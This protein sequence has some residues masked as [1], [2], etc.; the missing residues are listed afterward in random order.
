MTPTRGGPLPFHIRFLSF[1]FIS[2]LSYDI[3]SMGNTDYSS[4]LRTRGKA[5]FRRKMVYTGTKTTTLQP[6]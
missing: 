5:D 2:F 1:L 3:H 6:A 4:R